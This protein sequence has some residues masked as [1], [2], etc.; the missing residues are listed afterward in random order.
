MLSESWI[1][2]WPLLYFAKLKE[3]AARTTHQCSLF[4]GHFCNPLKVGPSIIRMKLRRSECTSS[5][6]IHY[7]I[8]QFDF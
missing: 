5:P 1:G 6:G 7:D 3:I 8:V 4:H 2:P